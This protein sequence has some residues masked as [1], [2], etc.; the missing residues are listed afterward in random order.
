MRK[1]K[2][3]NQINGIYSVVIPG[4]SLNELSKILD[5]TNDLIEI[6]ITENQVLF[7]AKNLLFFSRLLEGNYPDTSRLI[8][9]DSK[10]DVTVKYKGIFTSY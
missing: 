6:V 4:K 5:D 9:T 1:A 3:E 10:T 2:I 7:K 8:P